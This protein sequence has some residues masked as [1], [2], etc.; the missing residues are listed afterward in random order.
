MRRLPIILAALMVMAFLSGCEKSGDKTEVSI[1]GKLFKL[2]HMNGC[3]ECHRI[4]ATVVGPSWKAIAE[5]YKEAPTAD[6]RG[7]L[8]ERVKKG[9]KGNWF[10]FKG[11]HGMPPM[12]RR[13]SE[14]HINQM[15]DY[16]LA[17]R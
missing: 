11:G 14:D 13:V 1:A 3:I 15:V 17:L 4:D 6:I 16:I 9:S 10:T 5:R 8:I 7:L 2:G 12:E